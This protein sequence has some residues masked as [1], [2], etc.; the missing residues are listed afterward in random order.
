MPGMKTVLFHAGHEN[1]LFHAHARHEI[2]DGLLRFV[3]GL[4]L[5]DHGT[6]R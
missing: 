2:F 6:G 1:S 3:P 5:R 4:F